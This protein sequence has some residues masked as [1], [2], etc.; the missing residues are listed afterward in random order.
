M[1]IHAVDTRHER[2]G[3][4]DHGRHRKDLDDLVLLDV[5]EP[6]RGVL[7]IVQ[8]LEAEIG[9]VDERVDVLDH[10]L[11]ARID[12]VGETLRAQDARQDALT[13]EDILAQQHRALQQGVDAVDHL[14]VDRVLRIDVLRQGCDLFGDHLH[15]VGVVVDAHL[16]Q[17][18][19]EVV[20]RREAAVAHLQPLLGLAKRA[21]FGRAHR[22][23]HAFVR[24]DERHGLHDERIARRH[25]EV[26]VGDDGVLRL[27]I[28]RGRLDLLDLLLGLEADLHEAF[29]GL[30]L[31]DRGVQQ[32]DP[33][34][35]VVPQF[36]EELGIGI[37]DDLVVLFEVNG[38]HKHP[39]CIRRTLAAAGSVGRI[40]NSERCCA[41]RRGDY[42]L[43]P[44]ST[45]GVTLTPEVQNF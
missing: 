35:V 14:L 44:G 31:L 27:G 43:Q 8:T 41:R 25:E 34:D 37:A 22:H 3:H 13:V 5:D 26:G 33:Q 17:R 28:L 32:I 7:D 36:V 12:V 6:Q 21:E 16:Q 29:D 42:P 11:Q 45:K 30:L 4:E 40:V 9:M 38:N 24:N 15:Q 18:D 10:Q 20:A 2:R 23:Q 19:E 1:E 39:V